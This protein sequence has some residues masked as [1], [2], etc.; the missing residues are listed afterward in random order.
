MHLWEVRA[1]LQN[2]SERI[3]LCYERAVEARKRA[4]QTSDPTAKA[5]LL[6]TERR[7]LLLARSYQ[8]SESLTDFIRAIP[9]RP[10]ATAT[11]MD[12]TEHRSSERSLRNLE[13]HLQTVIDAT[14]LMF[15]RCS[16]DLRYHFVS[17]AYAQMI[18]REPEDVVGRSIIDVIGEEAF[19]TIL[20]YIRQVLQGQRVEYES[21]IQ[22]QGIGQRVIRA[23]YTPDRDQKGNIYGWIASIID[24]SDRVHAVRV[25]QQLA[26]IV[27]SSDDAIV[28]KDLNGV[29]ISWNNGAERIFGYSA[30]EVVGKSITILIPPDLKDEEPRILEHIRRGERI[31]HYETKRRHKDGRLLDV[32]LT[33]SPV[34]DAHGRIVGAS[35]I[36]RDIT[37]QKRARQR[38]AADL[39]A[40]TTLREVASLCAREGEDFSKCL[41]EILDA[42]IAI[43]GAHKGYVKLLKSET[44]ALT[45]AAERG[46]GPAFLKYFQH[47]RDEASACSAAMRSG[48]RVVV[49]DV[50]SCPLFI[51]QRS[52]NVLIDAGVR[53]VISTPLMSAAG[54]ILGVIST[55]F[56]EP[57]H[58]S[59]RALGLM[60]L[61][62]RQAAD[63]LERRRAKEIEE[64]L[65]RELQHRSNNQLAVI[66]A[67][68][69]HTLSG[70][71]SLAEAKKAFDA[72]LQALARANHQLN[73][74]NW[75]RVNLSEIV[76]SVLAPFGDRTMIDGVNVMVGPQYVQ[77]FSLALHE[78]AT[79]AAKY[80]ALSNESGR[81]EIFWTIATGEKDNILKFTWKERGG[82]PAMAPTRHG[83]G[84]L[85]L[86]AT[87]TNLRIDYLVEG[88]SCE[89]EL[90]LD[91]AQRQF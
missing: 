22:Y 52:M 84:T 16:S 75:S 83:L 55:H 6:N 69:H 66:Q 25:R 47:V 17:R 13:A 53:A 73:E 12:L 2:L 3:R 70:N 91:R 1:M 51:G 31:D 72:R 11:L 86:R 64:T 67:I 49:E 89:I 63:Y 44:G 24:I 20:P 35:K 88:L 39:W 57:H 8:H 68:A 71:R 59:A 29:I 5:D 37:Y 74:S 10:N 65:V 42:A 19:N 43:A 85:L 40:M 23:I 60:D 50:T 76:R 26:S 58:P 56:R 80:G 61:L 14:P 45:I 38:M 87:F 30:D 62:A 21:E 36:A 32:S 27:D 79:N 54:N 9:D 4:L 33:V 81:V 77:N 48:E 41:H 28:S 7:W 34:K 90:L 78:L 46:F 15:T 18:G 82:P